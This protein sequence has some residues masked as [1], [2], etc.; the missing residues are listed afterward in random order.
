MATEADI[1]KNYLVAV[2]FKTDYASFTGVKTALKDLEAKIT[3]HTGAMTSNYVKAG[4]IIAS[5]LASIAA[6]TVTMIDH[7]TK[8]D[9]SYQK[10][11]LQMYMTK[12]EAKGLKIAMDAMGESDLSNIARSES[13]RLN[14]SHTVVSRMPSSA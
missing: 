3:E 4:T 12:Q 7:V 5:S 11:A 10:F 9:L 13:T 6:A 8:A 14:S 2:G 1:L